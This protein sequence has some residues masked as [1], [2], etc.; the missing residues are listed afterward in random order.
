MPENVRA[1]AFLPHDL[2]LPL[3]DVMVTNG[4]WGGVLAAVEH[5]VPLVVA[6]G[7]LDK[8]EV[9]RRVARAGVGLDLRTGE[10]GRRRIRRAVATVLDGPEFRRRARALAAEL[11]AAGG[12]PAA[13][14]LVEGLLTP[15]RAGDDLQAVAVGVEPVHAATP[16]VGVDPARFPT[17]RIGPVR[18]IPFLDPAPDPVELVLTDQERVVLRMHRLV[19][20]EDVERH[21][22]VHLDHPERTVRPGRCQAED[23]DQELGGLL[24]VPG[25]HDGVVQLYGHDLPPGSIRMTRVAQR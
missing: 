23:L 21:S 12:I 13:A 6:G 2:L 20:L 5:G 19:D 22:V 18:Q 9:A 24:A 11:A 1:A 8:P 14:D 15:V 25:L 10:P 16:V 7:S 3:V 4:G 17:H